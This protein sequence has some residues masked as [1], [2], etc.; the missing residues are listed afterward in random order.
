[1][2]VADTREDGVKVDDKVRET[3]KVSQ[4]GKADMQNVSQAMRDI[5][6]VVVKLQHAID[7]VGKASEEIMDITGVIGSIAEETNLLSLNAS[8]EAARAGEAGRGFAVVATEIGH[9]AQTS[10]ESVK[11]I[12]RLIS[13]INILVKDAVGQA[14]DSVENISKSSNLVGNALITF[15]SIFQNIDTVNNLVQQMLEKV[16]K[17]DEV[18]GM[19]QQFQKNRQII[20][21]ETVKVWQAVREN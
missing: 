14:A 13:E 7:K 20:S 11:N 10:T 4:K 12:D 9:L 5:N 19:L 16:E 8:I 17:V 18:A 3:V 6:N 2:V 15:D 21:L 1:M